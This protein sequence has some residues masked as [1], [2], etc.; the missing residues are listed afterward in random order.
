MHPG[1]G[2]IV[3]RRP[4]PRGG[5]ERRLLADKLGLLVVEARGAGL[6]LDELQSALADSWSAL[7]SAE[8]HS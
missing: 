6:S 5:E 4:V 8:P 1:I 2:T 3:A 7:N